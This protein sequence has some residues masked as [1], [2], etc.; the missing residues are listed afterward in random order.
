MTQAREA[1]V[2]EDLHK[3]FGAPID[4]LLRATLGSPDLLDGYRYPFILE[5]F[6]LTLKLA[7]ASLALAVAL[8]MI[9]AVA[10]LSRSRLARV[11]A[12]VYTTV[13]SCGRDAGTRICAPAT[14]PG[15]RPTRRPRSRPGERGRCVP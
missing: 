1:L 8:G 4:A 11:A 10:K 9:G 6:A 12:G 7:L 2:V 3:S 15:V 14:Q 13:A 5:G